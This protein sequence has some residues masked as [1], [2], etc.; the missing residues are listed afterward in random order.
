VGEIPLW[1]QVR[2]CD[3]D[4][5]HG[6]VAMLEKVV[7]A[8]R[9]RCQQARIIVR[10]D[11]GFCREEIL[12]FCESQRE[13]YSC[14]GLGKNPVLIEKLGPTLAQARARRCLSAVPNPNP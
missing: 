12:A 1:A 8:I 7:A 13:V 10:G 11:S 9:K 14:V 4:G 2:T 3:H 6:V 5:A